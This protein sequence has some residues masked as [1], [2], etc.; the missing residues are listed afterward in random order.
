MTNLV[1][2]W[3]PRNHWNHEFTVRNKTLGLLGFVSYADYLASPY[4]RKRAKQI[5]V[6][7]KNRCRVC[8]LR[9]ADVHHLTYVRLG[10]ELDL[11]LLLLCRECHTQVHARYP[12][13]SPT[14]TVIPPVDHTQRSHIPNQPKKIKKKKGPRQGPVSSRTRFAACTGCQR[15]TAVR[16]GL[17]LSCR[18]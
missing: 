5:R 14:V 16:D 15:V 3:Q 13:S 6:R 2:L 10:R 8:R 12:P 11:D 17:C 18:T 1:L 9:A 7:D 4:W